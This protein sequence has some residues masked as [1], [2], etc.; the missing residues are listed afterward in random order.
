MG[1]PSCHRRLTAIYW[2][3]R[4]Q[5]EH[6]KPLLWELVL[7]RPV[8]SGIEISVFDPPRR[9][10]YFRTRRNLV[11][12][13]LSFP[14]QYGDYTGPASCLVVRTPVFIA[15]MYG[16]L[17][18]GGRPVR[19]CRRL[20]SIDRAHVWL[21]ARP[22][23]AAYLS[24]LAIRTSAVS[25]EYVSLNGRDQKYVFIRHRRTIKNTCS[26]AIETK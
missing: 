4:A 7:P 2:G 23:A 10:F 1:N 14:L 3:T 6:W 12:L 11:N 25:E 20:L 24:S 13:A 19:L 26:S 21:F 5:A 16:C 22:G 8:R 15:V 9:S 17:P 18:T